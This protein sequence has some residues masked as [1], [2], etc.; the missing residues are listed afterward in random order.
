MKKGKIVKRIIL[1]VLAVVLAA[2]CLTAG[3]LFM[4]YPSYLKS[5]KEAD[6]LTA[7]YNPSA[8]KEKNFSQRY[9]EEKS[10]KGEIILMSF[11]V[12]CLNPMDLGHRNWFYRAKYVIREVNDANPAVVGFQEVTKWQYSFLKKTMPLYDS[13]I[14]YRDDAFNSEGCPV[15]YRRDMFEPVDKGSFWLSETPDR[16]S[17]YEGAACYRICSFVVLKEKSSGREFA[18]FNTHLDHVSD[19]ARIYGIGV[20]MDKIKAFGSLPSVIMG[21]FNARE[22]SET[23]KNVT[24][25]F[26]DVK[27]LTKTPDSGAT[28]HNWGKEPDRTCID[29]FMI[30]ETGFRV[31]SFRVVR[32]TFDGDFASDHFPILTSLTL[33]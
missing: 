23:Y 18:V 7:Q 24:A 1:T 5:L 12:R 31:N 19:E 29:Y 32:D 11:N 4:Y 26:A 2:G 14:D 22:D 8:S 33:R 3:S 30:S 16:M 27:Y 17:R 25:S 15:F 6:S 28:Y 10:F 13:V 20:V 21:D 9:A